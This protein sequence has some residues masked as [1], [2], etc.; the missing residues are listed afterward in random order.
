MISSKSCALFTSP[1]IIVDPHP[2]DHCSIPFQPSE[3]SCVHILRRFILSHIPH[4]HWQL[5]QY[6]MPHP[7]HLLPHPAL[8]TQSPASPELA[9]S[10]RHHLAQPHHLTVNLIPWHEPLVHN[11]HQLGFCTHRSANLTAHVVTLRLDTGCHQ[12]KQWI[13]V[14]RTAIGMLRRRWLSLQRRLE[15]E[16]VRPHWLV[17]PHHSSLLTCPCRSTSSEGTAAPSIIVVSISAGRLLLC[18]PCTRNMSELD[19][20]WK[21]ERRCRGCE[22]Q[23]NMKATRESKAKPIGDDVSWVGWF[24]CSGAMANQSGRVLYPAARCSW[25]PWSSRRRQAEIPW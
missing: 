14:S 17:P 10:S 6:T 23:S 12:R 15:C 5:P 1:D 3:V 7:S 9:S 11:C 20:S 24:W 8:L 16:G 25:W 19:T 22:E 4:L 2:L 21:G 18:C 13:A